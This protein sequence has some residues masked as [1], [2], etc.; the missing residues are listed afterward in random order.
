MSDAEKLAKIIQANPGAVAIID[1]DAWHLTKPTPSG[2]DELSNHEQDEWVDSSEL[3][4]SADYPDLPVVYGY[5]LL[6][7]MAGIL[8]IKIESV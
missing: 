8:N 5:G 1:N 3:A 6:V 7:A 2:W 4:H